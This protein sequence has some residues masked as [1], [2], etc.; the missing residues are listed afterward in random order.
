MN[1]LFILTGGVVLLFVASCRQPKPRE[2]LA[3]VG[4]AELT[5]EDAL[6]QVDSSQKPF[7]HRLK[8]YVSH[9]VDDEIIYQEAKRIG[10]D[11]TEWLQDEIRQ[12]NRQLTIQAFLLNRM[13]DDTSN[14]D[15]TRLKSYFNSHSQEF[16]MRDD[17]IKLNLVTFVT[18][19]QAAE[20]AALASKGT[21]W[22]EALRRVASDTASGPTF[23]SNINQRYFSQRTL[24]P[25]ELWKVASSLDF[26]EISFPVRFASGYCIIQPL[27]GV[28]KGQPA[29]FELVRNEVQM[30]LQV[31]RRRQAYIDMLGT[32]RT[33]YNVEIISDSK[34]IDTTEHFHRE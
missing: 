29:P 11:K 20:F 5:V 14:I 1:Q 30:R 26:G 24:F 21:S 31:E 18:R 22:N 6:A 2:F 13:E 34:L 9:W 25:S 12:A 8:E 23:M 4:D 17:E 19:Q 28:Q 32:L 16:F 27:G 15:E 33:R 7:S 10:I 3:R